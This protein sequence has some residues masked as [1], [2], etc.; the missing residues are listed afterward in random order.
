[1]AV[2]IREVQKT[3]AQSSKRLIESKIEQLGVG[4]E[5]EVLKDQIKTPGAG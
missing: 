1:L 5:F 4:R 3:L 2:C